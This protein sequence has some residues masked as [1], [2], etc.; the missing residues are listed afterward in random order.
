MHVS[1]D[2]TFD[3]TLYIQLRLY[4]ASRS[5]MVFAYIVDDLQY[6]PLLRVTKHF[7]KLFKLQAAVEVCIT[8]TVS[9]ESL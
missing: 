2:V 8:V 7:Q 9:W 6:I 1:T 4:T 5:D 3:I